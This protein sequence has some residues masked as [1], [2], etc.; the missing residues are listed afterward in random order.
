M[1]SPVTSH[2]CEPSFRVVNPPNRPH[3]ARLGRFPGSAGNQVSGKGIVAVADGYFN[4]ASRVPEIGDEAWQRLA[5]F[6]GRE[7]LAQDSRFTTGEARKK[8][9]A[10]LEQLVRSSVRGKT[11]REVWEGLRDLGYWGAPVLSVSE[12]LNDEHV[13]ARKAFLQME[14]PVAGSINLVAPWIR[15]SKTPTDI[16]QVSPLIGEHTDEVLKDLL[17][18]TPEEIGKLRSQ[19]AIQ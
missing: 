19:G 6:I 10:E 9:K 4:F 1:N 16:R 17:R 13:K 2:L 12:V 3:S 18:L 14:H 15:M 5:A 7:D 11:R 8:N